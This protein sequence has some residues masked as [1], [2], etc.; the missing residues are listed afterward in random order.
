[1]ARRNAETRNIPD[2]QTSSEEIA[3]KLT[4]RIFLEEFPKGAKLPS[5][6][7]LAAEYGVARNVVREAVKRLQALG[8]VQSWRGSGMYVRDIE[9]VRGVDLFDTLVTHEDG[10]INIQFLREVIEFGEDF[11]RLVVRLAASH[12]SDEEL[13]VIKR[14]AQ[15][16]REFRENPQELAQRGNDLYRQFI[17]ATHNRVCLGLFNT[18]ERISAKL[19]SLADAT[20]ID[21][22]QK[23]KAIQRLIEALEEKDPMM[24]EVT[25]VRHLQALKDLFS[26]DTAPRDP[27]S[28]A[29]YT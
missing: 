16:W 11:I 19:F 7:E 18:L 12:R 2:I 17:K 3:K 23:Q 27:I 22:E 6:R 28:L 9:F 4:R 5:E 29:L 24:A 13:E 8:A 15:E 21:F 10:S 25:V 26:S 14:Q 1:M 20:V